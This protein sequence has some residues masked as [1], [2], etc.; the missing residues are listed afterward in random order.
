MLLSDSVLYLGKGNLELVYIVEAN[1]EETLHL[2]RIR[3][4]KFIVFPQELHRIP[5]PQR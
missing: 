5:F 1:T 3:I 2:I 4:L